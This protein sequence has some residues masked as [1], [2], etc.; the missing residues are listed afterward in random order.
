MSEPVP[1]PI[2]PD[3]LLRHAAWVRALARALVGDDEADDVVQETWVAAL[4]Q[5]PRSPAAL[6][7]WLG[8]VARNFARQRVRGEQRR[9]EREHAS[10]RPEALPPTDDVVERAATHRR[11]VELVLAL[12]EPGRT[13]VLLR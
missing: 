1:A 11:L 10:S 8:T 4:T 13:A 12:P 2:H 5:P 9:L 6:R 7:S 3:E